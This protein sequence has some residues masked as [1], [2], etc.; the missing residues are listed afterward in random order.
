MSDDW[1]VY[2]GTVLHLGEQRYCS[3]GM[4][5]FPQKSTNLMC[6][7]LTSKYTPKYKEVTCYK[8]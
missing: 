4:R 1:D 2:P 3:K 5:Y 8:S 7:T 6:S